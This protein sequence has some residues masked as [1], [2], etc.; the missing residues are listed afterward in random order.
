MIDFTTLR[1]K[2][3]PDPGAEDTLRLRT[4][5]VQTMNADGTVDILVSGATVPSVPRLDDGGWLAAG[6]VVQVLTLRGGRIILGTVS[7]G[8]RAVEA[9]NAGNPVFTSTSYTSLT[10]TDI[11][12]VAFIAPASGEVKI[13]VEGWL[14]ANSATLQRRT[15]L[16]GQVREGSAINSGTVVSAAD[17]ERAGIS[18]NSVASIHDYK[19]VNVAYSVT[20]LTPGDPYNVVS[21]VR[22][23][24]GDSSAAND[25]R[26]LVE[27]W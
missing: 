23:S 2:L 6:A 5:I 21:M 26:L 24:N 8:A 20:G 19:Y 12:G 25:R 14:S 9:F 10:T 4:A 18:Q 15:F 3:D 13:T 11:H 22:T 27:P 7:K 1:K 16:T 17:D